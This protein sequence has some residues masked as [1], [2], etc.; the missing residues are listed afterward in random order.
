[1][2]GRRWTPEDVDTLRAARADPSRT[3]D[4][5]VKALGRTAK[6]IRAKTEHLNLPP[7][8]VDG[9]PWSSLRKPL[10]DDEKAEIAR[11]RAAGAT[12]HQVYKAVRRGEDLIRAHIREIEAPPPP[13]APAANPRGAEPWRPLPPG[14]P[15]AMRE[16]QR[17][18]EIEL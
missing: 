9:P 8:P 7:W 14:H 1:M 15:I 17:A 16:L 3:I 6:A 11:L 2:P 13:P 5:A 18:R 12:I 10:T 4:D